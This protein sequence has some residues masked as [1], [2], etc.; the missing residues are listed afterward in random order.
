MS[1]ASPSS[2][3]NLLNEQRRNCFGICAFGCEKVY[4]DCFIS[5]NGVEELL[6]ARRVSFVMG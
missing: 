4:N 2:S 3:Q 1:F 5:L 6:V